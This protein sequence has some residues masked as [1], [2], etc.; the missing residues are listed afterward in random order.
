MEP[1]MRKKWAQTWSSWL[2]P[3][4]ELVTMMFPV[5]SQER[6][7]PPWPVP[8]ELYDDTLKP[9]GLYISLGDYQHNL[10]IHRIMC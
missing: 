1:A 8:V 4:G 9:E 6:E 3:G 5:E 7:G 10:C 2:Q